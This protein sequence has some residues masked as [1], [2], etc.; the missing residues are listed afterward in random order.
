MF[1]SKFISTRKIFLFCTDVKIQFSILTTPSFL[2]TF[3]LFPYYL[4]YLVCFTFRAISQMII[5]VKDFCFI[6]H[7]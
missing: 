2:L 5:T 6:T 7:E 4:N 1:I 3:L